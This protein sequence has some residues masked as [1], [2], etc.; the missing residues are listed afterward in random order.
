MRAASIAGAQAHG[1]ATPGAASR[2]AAGRHCGARARGLRRR[3][4]SGTWRRC[5]A[6]RGEPSPAG[7]QWVDYK[8]SFSAL[9]VGCYKIVGQYRATS[10][11][12]NYI[13]DYKV[14]NTA[15]GDSVYKEVQKKGE[16]EYL[17]I[18]IGTYQ[19]CNN[20]YVRI[21]DPGPKSICFNKM[22]FIYLGATCQ[23]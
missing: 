21:Q 19:L 15:T 13:V 16:G 17:D 2:V 3:L 12:A 8:P 6:V 10:S 22:K 9:G 1:P 7:E 20:S 5:G 18:Q 14:I 23:N 4:G 11:R